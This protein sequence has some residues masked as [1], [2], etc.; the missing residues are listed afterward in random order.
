MP[1]VTQRFIDLLNVPKPILRAIAEEREIPQAASMTQWQLAER[2]A[3]LPRDELEA[4]TKGFLYAGRTSVTYFRLDTPADED[5]AAHGADDENAALEGAAIRVERVERVLRELSATD[6]FS[7]AHRPENVTREPQLVVAHH[8]DDGSILGTFVV[9]G[10]VGQ[11]IHEFRIEP[12]IGDDFFSA[13]F[14]PD[15]GV[16][17]VRTGQQYADRFGRTWLKAFAQS[18]G[19]EVFPVSITQ[20]D[21]N[22]L[23]D[24]LDAGTAAFRGKNTAGGAVDTIEVR[25]APG[26]STLRGDQTFEDKTAGTEQQLGDLVFGYE[27]S[28]YRIRVSRIRGSIYFVRAA[29]E[30]VLEH[31]REALRHV[32]VRHLRDA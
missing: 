21:F 10:A 13:V 2:L 8:R 27:G 29:P 7:E 9:E 28:E 14:H 23:G 32:K 31:V 20:A 3:D 17:E 22:A 16:V 12:V 11:V 1:V 24:E 18:L 30:A 4:M 25:M 5:G 6:P 26:F 15:S 19:L